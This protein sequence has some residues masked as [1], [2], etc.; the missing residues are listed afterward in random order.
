MV[1]GHMHQ[2]T[3][4][5]KQNAIKAAVFEIGQYRNLCVRAE[6]YLKVILDEFKHNLDAETLARSSPYTYLREELT[7]TPKLCHHG[8]PTYLASTTTVYINETCYE[9]LQ[10]II[11]K[12]TSVGLPNRFLCPMG[13]FEKELLQL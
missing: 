11:G 9:S 8:F 7:S 1:V 6:A 5:D 4:E 2:S 3:G 12:K 10:K 13:A